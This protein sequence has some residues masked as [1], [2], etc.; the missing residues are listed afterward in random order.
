GDWQW[1]N[2][3]DSVCLTECL[4]P[5]PFLTVE[6]KLRW[7]ATL[8]GRLGYAWQSWL[9][10]VTGGAAWGSVRE[11]DALSDDS[12]VPTALAGFSQTRSGWTLGGGIET[13]LSGNWSAKFEYLYVDLGTT[14]NSF[15][16]TGSIPAAT[17]AE[18]VNTH[19][20]D[21]VF[22]VGLNYRFG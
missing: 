13:A 17:L 14:T 21:N 19:V 5:E 15:T 22:R 2:Q 3:K 1:A 20:R 11:N 9:W 16:F 8:R 12:T 4:I 10:F 18:T 6:Q 7:L